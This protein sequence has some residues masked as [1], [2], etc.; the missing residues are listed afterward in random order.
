VARC[1]G[2]ADI[3]ALEQRCSSTTQEA[4]T[5]FSQVQV[6]QECKAQLEVVQQQ[7][8]SDLVTLRKVER[9]AQVDRLR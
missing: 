5:L 4:G 6:L 3:A 2:S 1:Y 7:R 9:R 8:A